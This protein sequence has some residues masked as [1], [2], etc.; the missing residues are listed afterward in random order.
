MFGISI[1]AGVFFLLYCVIVKLKA[2]K[3]NTLTVF[4]CAILRWAY[5][6]VF[7]FENRAGAPFFVL[8][9]VYCLRM[10]VWAGKFW[11]VKNLE[12]RGSSIFLGD[13]GE[14]IECPIMLDFWVSTYRPSRILIL[15]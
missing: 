1:Y 11:G 7:V 4:F 3:N 14:G 6:P 5:K 2:L 15:S 9:I 10:G 12:C 8:R 13:G